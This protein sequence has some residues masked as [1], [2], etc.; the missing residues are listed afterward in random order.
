MTMNYNLVFDSMK[1]GRNLPTVRRNALPASS[2]SKSK[3]SEQTSCLLVLLFDSE[4]GGS[5]LIRNIC[6]VPTQLYGVISQKMHH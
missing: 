6:Y 3:T 2:G 4:H 5:R 1:S